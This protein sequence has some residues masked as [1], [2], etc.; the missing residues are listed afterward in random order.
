VIVKSPRPRR[1][2]IRLSNVCNLPSDRS[3]AFLLAVVVYE[4]DS[5]MTWSAGWTALT[6]GAGAT[7]ASP[8]RDEA[9]DNVLF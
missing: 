4:G 2:S 8:D 5:E 1:R 7:P 3:G 6:N 9:G